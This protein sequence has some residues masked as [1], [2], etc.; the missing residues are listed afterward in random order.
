MAVYSREED[1][2]EI[3]EIIFNLEVFPNPSENTSTLKITG[4]D[5]N[6]AT[7]DVF[8]SKGMQI[9]SGEEV[10]VGEEISFG[11]NLAQGIYT[12][13]AQSNGE[14]KTVKYIKK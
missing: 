8:D 4:G 10:R 3:S 1:G 9:I 7:I 12:I 13:K 11:N 5:F 14:Q 6:T 2:E